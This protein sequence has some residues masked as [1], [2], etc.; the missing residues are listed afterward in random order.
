VSSCCDFHPRA[1]FLVLSHP[2]ARHLSI[3]APRP[4]QQGPVPFAPRDPTPAGG[5]DR[6]RI[7][8]SVTPSKLFAR[9]IAACDHTNALRAK[10]VRLPSLKG[11]V[12]ER[13]ALYP[14]Y[15]TACNT[16][17]WR[18]NRAACCKRLHD[19]AMEREAENRTWSRE[20]EKATVEK[21]RRKEQV[22][23]DR[24]YM[25]YPPVFEEPP[26]VAF[27]SEERAAALYDIDSFNIT[28]WAE[29]EAMPCDNACGVCQYCKLVNDDF[30]KQ[31]REYRFYNPF[32]TGRSRATCVR[33][34]L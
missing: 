28:P 18:D 5:P 25:L 15:Q 4:F 23:S 12:T 7:T 31:H 20:A 22:L 21:K 10:G 26:V 19:A 9:F 3:M 2:L 8:S 29:G 17:V 33:P 34:R 6:P 24:L 16:Y 32:C 1:T 11:S 30:A 13:N 14:T 27:T